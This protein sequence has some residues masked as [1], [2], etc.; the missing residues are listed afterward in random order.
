[1][2][3]NISALIG[4]LICGLSYA[5]YDIA[6]QIDGLS[7]D[8]E[9]L[10]ANHFGDK[11]YLKDTA[12][13]SNGVFHFKGEEK[14]ESGVYLIVLP[15]K[16][17]FEVLVSVN[18]NQMEYSF[19]A[20]TTLKPKKMFVSGSKENELFLE[21]NVFAVEQSLTA[22]EIRKEMD[23]EEN[24]KKKESLKETLVSIGESV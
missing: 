4:L 16:N 3:R 10:L 11:Q 24:E 9:L 18:E 20:D 1:M 2:T 7:C 13:C 21:F 8:D 22:A 12:E 23:A 6:V 19:V 15:K 14:L 5:Q 17:Y